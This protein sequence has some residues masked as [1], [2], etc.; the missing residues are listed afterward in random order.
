MA[1]SSLNRILTRS[2]RGAPRAL[3][4]RFGVVMLMLAL[5]LSPFQYALASCSCQG[6]Q[7]CSQIDSVECCESSTD[8]CCCSEITNSAETDTPEACCSGCSSCGSQ[9]R[10]G[11]LE[12][13]PSENKVGQT[14]TA[15]SPLLI[16]KLASTFADDSQRII[17]SNQVSFPDLV[18]LRLHAFHCVWLN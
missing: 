8:C 14:Q 10:C 5:V 13:A 11:A 6:C 12:V 3:A 7:C 17:Q 16:S 4:Q 9:C 2:T 18:S 15:G 1:F